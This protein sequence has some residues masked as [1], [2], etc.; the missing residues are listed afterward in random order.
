MIGELV[1]NH[2]M[3]FEEYKPPYLDVY[4]LQNL[5]VGINKQFHLC[6]HLKMHFLGRFQPL[7]TTN[8]RTHLMLLISPPNY[9]NNYNQ[10]LNVYYNFGLLNM[11]LTFP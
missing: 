2:I 11:P 9:M 3:L 6:H 1:V 4:H 10:H 7:E 8:P 5:K